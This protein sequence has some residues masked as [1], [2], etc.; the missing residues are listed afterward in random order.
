[1]QNIPP[2]PGVTI[3]LGFD[4]SE[5]RDE[6]GKWVSESANLIDQLSFESA[7]KFRDVSSN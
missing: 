4:P 2:I 1:M 3:Q 7:T 6:S 5:A